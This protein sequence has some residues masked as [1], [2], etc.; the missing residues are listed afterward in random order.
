MLTNQN[1]ITKGVFNRATFSKVLHPQASAALTTCAAIKP[2]ATCEYAYQIFLCLKQNPF[3]LIV[4][5]ID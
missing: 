4:L 1:V 5:K 3:L 2:S